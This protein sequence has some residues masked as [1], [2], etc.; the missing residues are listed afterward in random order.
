MKRCISENVLM[1]GQN[2]ENTQ[3]FKDMMKE[4]FRHK[5]EEEEIC[6]NNL[7]QCNNKRR[8]ILMK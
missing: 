2:D 7:D 3:C 4:V 1:K 8:L 6:L 5:F